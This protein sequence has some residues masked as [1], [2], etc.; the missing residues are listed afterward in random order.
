M[1]ELVKVAIAF[2]S[3]VLTAAG[4]KDTTIPSVLIGIAVLVV[5]GYVVWIK[6]KWIADRLSRSMPLAEA[7]RQVYEAARKKGTGSILLA[8]ANGEGAEPEERLKYVAHMFK[9]YLMG[10]EWTGIY[11]TGTEREVID[12]KTVVK[13]CDFPSLDELVSNNDK[14]RYR[15]VRITKAGTKQIIEAIRS[16]KNA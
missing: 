12:F 14:H 9:I 6:R 8:A 2:L 4:V 1:G 10:E 5:L 15:Q 16:D 3:G 13:N 7:A 11:S